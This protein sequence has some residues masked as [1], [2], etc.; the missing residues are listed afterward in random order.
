MSS[1]QASLSGP[2]SES[3]QSFQRSPLLG[4]QLRLIPPQGI[5]NDRS[6][7]RFAIIMQHAN[8]AYHVQRAY[9]GPTIWLLR[10]R[11][12]VVW[13]ISEKTSWSLIFSTR[14]ILQGSTCHIIALYVREKY[15][16]TRGSLRNRA[17]RYAS[18]VNANF[19]VNQ[20]CPIICRWK[21]VKHRYCFGDNRR[22]KPLNHP[23]PA[24]SQI[25]IFWGFF[26]KFIFPT[27]GRYLQTSALKTQQGVNKPWG[28][29]YALKKGCENWNYSQISLNEQFY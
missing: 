5:N 16:I 10:G 21:L 22:T 15:S 28:D 27:S 9:K 18:L 6:L 29:T 14:K 3:F 7:M 17:C 12:G 11:A 4:S 23:Y 25:I 1:F 20:M 13:M 19:S 24:Q 2:P 8:M 26:K